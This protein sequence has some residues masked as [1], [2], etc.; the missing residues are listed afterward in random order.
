MK[1]K[2][3]KT[4]ASTVVMLIMLGAI[5]F[6]FVNGFISGSKSGNIV[7]ASKSEVEKL[8]GKDINLHY[9]KNPAEVVKLY[10]RIIKCFYNEKMDSKEIEQMGGQASLLLDEELRNNKPYEEYLYDLNGE[11]KNYK[12]N[13]RTI[14]NYEVQKNSDVEKCTVDDMEYATVL[15]SYFLKENQEY[16]KVYEKYILR[17]GVDGEWR[18]L[19]WKAT[20]PFD[21]SN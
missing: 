10:S 3:K 14:V 8:L 18:I 6:Y 16:E 7:V 1:K 12:S 17:K 15:A 20:A 21:L 4:V 9:P 13:K 5:V 11:I 19:G 2:R